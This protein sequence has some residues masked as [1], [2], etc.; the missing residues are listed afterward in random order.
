M[1]IGPQY[2]DGVP[3]WLNAV[4]R[5]PLRIALPIITVLASLLWSALIWGALLCI[6][7]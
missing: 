6:P 2:D 3:V 5:L 4:D 7:D 1:L